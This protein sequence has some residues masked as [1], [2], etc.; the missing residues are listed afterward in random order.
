[1]L[2]AILLF[3]IQAYAAY[4]APL[5][6]NRFSL[7]YGSPALWLVAGSAPYNG[8][9]AAVLWLDACLLSSVYG[10]LGYTHHNRR[11]ILDVSKEFQ[12]EPSRLSHSGLEY[13]PVAQYRS[14]TPNLCRAGAPSSNPANL[15]TAVGDIR[16]AAVAGR[17]YFC[18][19]HWPR[20]KVR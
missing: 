8:N 13:I 11:G 19:K 15:G 12:K 10:G 4:Y 2:V 3:T 9:A 1:M 6:Q 5:Y 18:D 14:P 16:G 7:L 17:S 20:I